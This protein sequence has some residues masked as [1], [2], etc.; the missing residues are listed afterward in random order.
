MAEYNF[1]DIPLYNRQNIHR[2]HYDLIEV[3]GEGQIEKLNHDTPCA[4]C[5]LEVKY[6][7]INN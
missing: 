6:P 7:M 3:N 5:D 4:L 2:S 1:T